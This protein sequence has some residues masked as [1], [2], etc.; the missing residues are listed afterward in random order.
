MFPNLQIKNWRLRIHL[1]SNHLYLLQ[2]WCW[3]WCFSSWSP[4]SVLCSVARCLSLQANWLA[5]LSCWRDWMAG[6]VWLLLVPLLWRHL[7]LGIAFL[8][9]RGDACGFHHLIPEPSLHVTPR[10]HHHQFLWSSWLGLCSAFLSFTSL[11][12]SLSLLLLSFENSDCL[13]QAYPWR[14]QNYNEATFYQCAR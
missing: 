5:C 13:L 3:L 12:S 6:D 2:N 1:S 7:R 4:L 8:H 10:C 11:C 9:R 14:L